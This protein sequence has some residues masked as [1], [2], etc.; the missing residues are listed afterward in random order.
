MGIVSINSTS[1]E[2]LRLQG[3]GLERLQSE[4]PLI[5][6]QKKSCD[7]IVWSAR[8]SIA[9]V[10]INSTSE[11][12]LRRHDYQASD[13]TDM[14]GVSIN[15]TSEE[16][17]RLK[18]KSPAAVAPSFPLIRLQKKSCDIRTLQIELTRHERFH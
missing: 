7:S 18:R 11:E 15:S 4:F 8:I 5:R 2:V 10:S 14:G 12:V 16:V 13:I 9:P 1:E 3:I 17:L 6:L